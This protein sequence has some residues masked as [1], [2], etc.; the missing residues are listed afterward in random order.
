MSNIF[1]KEKFEESLKNT[2]EVGSVQKV[3]YPICYA[4]GLPSAFPYELVMFET[5]EFGQVSSASP[6]YVEILSFSPH[7]IDIGARVARTGKALEVPVGEALLGTSVDP[8][9]RSLYKSK[10]VGPFSEF[11]GIETVPLGIEHRE[12]IT[13]PLVTGV[14]IVDM[15]VPLGKGQRELVI[16]DRKTGKSSFLLQ[17]LLNQANQGTI[18]IYAAIG[19]K[20]TDIR[21]IEAFLEKNNLGDRSFIVASSSTDSAGIIY[22]TPYAAMT[23]AEYFK[24]QGKNVL[25]IL[26]DLSIHA[27]FYREISLLGKNFPGRNSYPGDIFY[28]HGRLVERAGNFKTPNGPVSITCL[29]VAETVEG[30]ISGYIQTNLMSMT[31]GHV[32]F[33]KDLFAQGRRP[34][35]NFFLSVTRVGRQTQ[36]SVRSGLNRELNSFLTLHEKT[37]SFVHFGAELS[38]GVKTT[39]AMGDKILDFFNQQPDKILDLNSQIILFCLIWIGTWNDKT[40]TD[41]RVELV[42]I[43]RAYEKSDE[44]QSLFKKYVDEATDFNALLGR[45]STESKLVL[46]AID[47][48]IAAQT[49]RDEPEISPE[50]ESANGTTNGTPLVPEEAVN[51]KEIEG[52][53]QVT[54]TPVQNNVT[55]QAQQTQPSSQIQPQQTDSQ[56]VANG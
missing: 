40:T 51:Q 26:D 24:D 4:D 41:T 53:P 35:V 39:L 15:M 18:C 22:L 1:S 19:K 2:G 12:K 17:T 31:D 16:G 32:Y 44:L 47:A 48:A 6:D 55:E 42:K 5:G 38:E 25:I 29:P 52:Q 45:L 33:D 10:P 7:P 46:D 54:A 11:R 23:M 13:E 9:G 34:A 50:P 49:G 14:S 8:L 43:M 30:D 27:K 20:K 56:E 21:H 28:T 37:Q 36:T 3:S